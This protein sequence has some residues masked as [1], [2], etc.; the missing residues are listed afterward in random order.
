M[1]AGH[2]LRRAE[3]NSW[4]DDDVARRYPHLELRAIADR[5]DEI[6]GA[7]DLAIV[8]FRRQMVEAAQTFAAGGEAIGAHKGRVPQSKLHSYEGI[9][10]KG[11]DWR[12]LGCSEEE[13]A[14][15]ARQ[16]ARNTAAE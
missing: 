1:T 8:A 16:A 5:G 12:T 10:A 6:L 11:Y 3:G 9:V 14:W 15:N 4:R 2:S 13:L 7:S